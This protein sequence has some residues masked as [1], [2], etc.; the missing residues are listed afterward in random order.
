MSGDP[1]GSLTDDIT[2]AF[3]LAPPCTV[4]DI[5]TTYYLPAG[6]IVNHGRWTGVPDLAHPGFVLAGTRPDH[7]TIV[8]GTGAYT[9]AGGRV[10]GWGV[11]DAHALP[12]QL[13]YDMFTVIRL[14][15]GGDR[16]SA[17]SPPDR[18]AQYC[19]SDGENTSSEPTHFVAQEV[20]SE[21]SL[22][23]DPQRPG[24][25]LVGAR[26]GHDTIT[27]AS[28]VFAGRT[29][30]VDISGSVDLRRF[31]AAA[32]FEGVSLVSLGP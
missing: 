4:F 31:P 16:L 5:E 7:D 18:I 24:F 25:G 13:G 9:G 27:A 17:A 19:T 3:A 32:P 23:P 8:S 10:N 11:V 29:G 28:G 21:V 20:Q 22:V 2:C 30:H 15:P 26:P 12:A 1:A 14:A 6:D